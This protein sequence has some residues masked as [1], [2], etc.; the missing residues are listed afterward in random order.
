MAKERDWDVAEVFADR[1]RS[2]W[3]QGVRRPAF[4]ALQ[5]AVRDRTVTAVIA[6][7]LSRLGRRATR[8]HEF[9][10]L[11]RE[12][13]AVLALYE[14]QI[15]T[16]T[17][18][19]KVFFGFVASMAELESDQT[20]ERVKSFHKF[21]AETGRMHTG[22]SRQ[23]GYERDGT[24]TV[25]ESEAVIIREVTARILSGASLR[26]IAFDLNDRGIKTTK[27]NSWSGP[28][29]RQM[30]GSPRLAGRRVYE[31]AYFNG[32]WEPILDGDVWSALQAKLD[33]PRPGRPRSV[34]AHL[35][36]GTAVCGICGGA[37][38]TMGFRMHNGR[39][40]E[41]YCCVRQPGSVNCGGVAAAK[42]SLDALVRDQ[43]LDFMSNAKLRPIEVG[44]SS[45]ELGALVEDLK[46]RI[47]TLVEDFYVEKAV[48]AENFHPAYRKLQERLSDA[49]AAFESAR[50]NE[51]E[52]CV[53]V[54]LGNRQA[55]EEWWEKA[56]GIERRQVLK[57]D[58]ARV[59]VNRAKHRGGNRFDP[60]RVKIEWDF[61]L[62]LRASDSEWEHM[63]HEEREEEI[64]KQAELNADLDR[65]EARKAG[66]VGQQ[67]LGPRTLTSRRA[68]RN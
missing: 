64:Q 18:V 43:W 52:R 21:A 50:R 44:K 3:K 7:S 58:I 11:L 17:P 41:R 26:S 61:S 28:T 60:E 13:G 27:G 34:Q 38:K 10:E 46:G 40:F 56:T 29:L 55:L 66:L 12:H 62:Y 68:S 59:V 19:G 31:G 24:G 14:Q 2:G 63:S 30:L 51:N 15:D 48:H 37:L 49:Q 16:S 5:A 8:L 45:E 42:N 1:D 6:Y 4:E 32:T 9:S 57:R 67:T 39:P 54:P 33:H 25:V 53:V 23:F 22:G 36:S 20:S 65:F 35:L 47:D